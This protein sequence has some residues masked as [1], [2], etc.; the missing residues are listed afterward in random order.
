[1]QQHREQRATLQAIPSGSAGTRATLQHMRRL[2]REYK[3][4]LP[5]RQLA[6]SIV[7]HVNGHKNFAGEVRAIHDYVRRNIRYVKDVNGVETLATPIA[8]LENRA[9]DCDDQS[10]LLATLLESIGHPTRFVAIKMR[11]LGPYVHV[12]TETRIG[13]R[14]VPLE[15]TE[16]WPAGMG[17]PKHAGKLIWNN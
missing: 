10:V 17:P 6:L 12:Y 8:T 7:R 13:P 2:V 16:N 3:K 14:W 1:M 15:T 9:G 4:T 5:M 11:P